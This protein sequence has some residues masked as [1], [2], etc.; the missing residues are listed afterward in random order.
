[1]V[2]MGFIRWSLRLSPHFPSGLMDT[3]NVSFLRRE[4][5]GSS[6]SEAGATGLG[7]ELAVPFRKAV[8]Q[9]HE[10]C[11]TLSDRSD[12]AVELTGL[13]Q[14]GDSAPWPR[15][16]SRDGDGQFGSSPGLAGS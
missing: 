10:S 12:S 3:L 2:E 16:R 13:G 5:S 8:D 4:V 11:T 7:L 14:D 1:M 9:A 15:R 6:E